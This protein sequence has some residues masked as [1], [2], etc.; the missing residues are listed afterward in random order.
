MSSWYSGLWHWGNS[1]VQIVQSAV[2]IHHPCHVEVRWCPQ[3]YVNHVFSLTKHEDHLYTIYIYTL[4]YTYNIYTY[5]YICY[6]IYAYTVYPITQLYCLQ[7]ISHQ[8]SD[9]VR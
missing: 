1:P 5:I 8:S 4:M 2:Q 9:S 3:L 7:A 6:L